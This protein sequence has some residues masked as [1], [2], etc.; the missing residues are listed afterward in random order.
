MARP[1]LVMT[2]VPAPDR[3]RGDGRLVAE[4]IEG[5]LANNYT[6]GFCRVV[7]ESVGGRA[8]SVIRLRPW[9]RNVTDCVYARR[10]DGRLR[11]RECLIGVGRKNAKS[12]LSSALRSPRPRNGR[13]WL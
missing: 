8:G 9:Q 13:P 11:H 5:T 4:F 12:T 1:P 2:P 7:K 6:D 10:P 3:K